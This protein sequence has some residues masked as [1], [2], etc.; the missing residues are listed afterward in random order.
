MEQKFS[1]RGFRSRVAEAGG[2]TFYGLGKILSV[3]RPTKYV[4][5]FWSSPVHGRVKIFQSNA[6]FNST[7]HTC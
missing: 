6:P 1:D 7:D 5:H 4:N 2:N 3:R